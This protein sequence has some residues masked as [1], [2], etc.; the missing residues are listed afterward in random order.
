[1]EK[2]DEQTKKAAHS[3]DREAQSVLIHGRR[4]DST[5]ILPTTNPLRHRHRKEALDQA[6]RANKEA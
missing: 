3:G 6:T 4:D 2:L 5:C 1:M